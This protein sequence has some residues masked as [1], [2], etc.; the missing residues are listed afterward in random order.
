M[1]QLKAA[2]AAAGG[3]QRGAHRAVD[4]VE[5]VALAGKADLGLGGVDVDVHQLGGHGQHQ[6]AAG[7]L[8]LHQRAL[9]GGLQRGHHGAV[10]D[11]AAVDVE[12]LRPAGGPAG[13]RRG[14]QAGQPVDAVAALH[15]QQVAGKLPPHRR[16]H[17]AEQPAV[18]GGDKLQLAFPLKPEGDLRVGKRRVQHHIRHKGALAGVLFQKFHAGGGVVEQVVDGDGGAHRAGARLHALGL[19]A[20]NAVKAGVLVRLG[21]GQHLHLGH[22][23]NGGQ[24]LAP[25]AQRVDAGQV[26]GGGDLAGGVADKGFVDVLGL[27]AG[28]VVHNL[29]L[30][31]AAAADG[32]RDLG[33]AGVDGVFQQLLRHRGGALDHLAGGDQLGGMLVQYANFSHGIPRSKK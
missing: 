31:D 11:I 33:G 9:V 27:D 5:H 2:L 26:V 25:K 28:A 29:Q 20:G 6:H 24:R 13:P 18:A 21:A 23:G 17:C 16:V 4:R 12:I 7:E 10:F 8:A 30:L 3:G 15:R 1:V 14:D 19:A 22:A 32:Q